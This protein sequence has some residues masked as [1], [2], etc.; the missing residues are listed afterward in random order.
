MPKGG[1]LQISCR[2]ET[3]AQAR[4][5]G[6]GSGRYTVVKIADTGICMA[7]EVLVRVVEPSGSFRRISVPKMR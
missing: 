1:T 2:H 6:L 5:S 4:P 3:V 7:P